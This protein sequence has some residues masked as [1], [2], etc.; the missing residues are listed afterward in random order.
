M[1]GI[2]GLSVAAGRGRSRCVSAHVEQRVGSPDESGG[3][4]WLR[5]AGLRSRVQLH[6]G[7]CGG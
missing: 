2:L 3:H 4:V 1:A 7:A 5:I 6:C